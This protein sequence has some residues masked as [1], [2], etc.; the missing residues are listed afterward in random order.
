MY[1]YTCIYIYIYIYIYTY[2]FI[3]IC[4]YTYLY[5]HPYKTIY[6]YIYT[7]INVHAVQSVW[8]ISYHRRPH[9]DRKGNFAHAEYEFLNLTYICVHAYKSIV[10]SVWGI[11]QDDH[12][13]PP[14]NRKGDFARAGNG[15]PNLRFRWTASA[16]R[17]R[18]D[19]QRS[20]GHLWLEDYPG[21]WLRVRY[22]WCYCNVCIYTR[23]QIFT[24]Y[25]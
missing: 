25:S 18:P 23:E 4:T 11:S 5:V 24:T 17:R 16:R 12:G 7:P 14:R 20:C 3:Y 9:H 8:G 19:T 2:I 1:I 21:R 22:S 6:M 10:Q 13:R 15:L